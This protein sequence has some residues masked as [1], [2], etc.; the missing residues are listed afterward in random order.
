MDAEWKF[1][2]VSG[3]ALQVLMTS[4]IIDSKSILEFL[5]F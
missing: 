2:V 1:R 4:D 3:C 5:S